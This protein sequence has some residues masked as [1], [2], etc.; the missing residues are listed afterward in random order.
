MQLQTF[1]K[2]ISE[3]ISSAVRRNEL[4]AETDV[5]DVTQAYG[6]F[7]FSVLVMALKKPE[8]DVEEETERVGTMLG[9]YLQ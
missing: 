3:L 2:N 9:K 1:L 6:S 5:F 8:F 7:Y 4:T